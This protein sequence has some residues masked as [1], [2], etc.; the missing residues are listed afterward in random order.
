MAAYMAGCQKVLI[1]AENMKDLEEIDP[2]VKENLIFIPC[3]TASD[4]LK[5]AL[6]FVS[7]TS[8]TE[9]SHSSQ[10]FIPTVSTVHN[11]NVP[12]GISGHTPQQEDIHS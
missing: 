4:A 1:P 10:P 5:E 9:V 2:I 7:G 6:V 8:Y 11:G 12:T 3:E